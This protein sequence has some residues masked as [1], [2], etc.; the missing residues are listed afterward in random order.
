M[1]TSCSSGCGSGG[2]SSCGSAGSCP[3]LPKPSRQGVGRIVAVGSGKG[4]VGKSTVSALM[5][6]ALSRRGHKVGIL[7]ADV[8][9]PSIPRM[10]GVTQCPW[11]D[12]DN[13]V[14]LPASSGGIKVMSMNLMLEDHNSPVVWRGP[15]IG[16]VIRQFWQ[17]VDWKGL[18]FVVV[19]LP[20][21]TAD[22][23]LTVMQT[24]AVDGMVAVTTPQGLSA[25]IVEKQ[26]RLSRMLRVPLLGLVENMSYALCPCCGN[27]WELFGPSHREEIEASL[28]LQTLARVPIDRKLAEACD[29]G[30]LEL[31]ENPELMAALAAVA[32]SV[33]PRSAMAGH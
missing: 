3:S 28:G 32:E 14:Q 15:L 9:G 13:L 6:L 29:T 27:Q 12:G 33:Q 24:I 31:Y 20:P 18:D 30:K 19:D 4:G 16:S 1:T 23:P 10:L 21:G 2:C 17:E 5:A 26:V 7:D 25:M 8:T 11:S 22:G